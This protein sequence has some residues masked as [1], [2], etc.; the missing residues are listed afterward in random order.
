[1][2]PPVESKQSTSDL[3]ARVCLTVNMRW[4]NL[5]LDAGFPTSET[6]GVG[7]RNRQVN[8]RRLLRRLI[9]IEVIQPDYGFQQVWV[10]PSLDLCLCPTTVEEIS[11]DRSG[12]VARIIH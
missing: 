3:S 10:S 7:Q 9:I 4:V 12:I 6:V 1:M 11:N 5:P 2:E 8:I